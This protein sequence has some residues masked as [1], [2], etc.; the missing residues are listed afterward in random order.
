[1]KLIE[2]LNLDNADGRDKVITEAGHDVLEI[3]NCNIKLID[4]NP[5][6]GTGAAGLDVRA[7]QL[8]KLTNVVIEGVNVVRKFAYGVRSGYSNTLAAENKYLEYD[9]VTIKN[10]G[11]PVPAYDKFNHDCNAFEGGERIRLKDCVF[12]SATDACM[13][14]KIKV[15]EAKR[16]KFKNSY[17]LIRHWNSCQATFVDCEFDTTFEHFWHYDNTCVTR[18]FN[19]KFAQPMKTSFENTP[20]QI[21]TLTSDPLTDPWFAASIVAPKRLNLTQE[22][23]DWLKA[24]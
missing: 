22:Q 20:G 10:L 4:N 12:D 19:C 21:I 2:N 3:K 8:V 18:L 17:R 23:L 11:A 6:S 9:R 13:D 14:G 16:T 7:C 5:T 24:L 15:I 1:M